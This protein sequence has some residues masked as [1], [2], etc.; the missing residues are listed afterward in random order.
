MCGDRLLQTPTL[1][2]PTHQHHQCGCQASAFPQGICHLFSLMLC[3][4][5]YWVGSQTRHW[6]P[7]LFWFYMTT[8]KKSCKLSVLIHHCINMNHSS[9][10]PHLIHSPIFR[11]DYTFKKKKKKGSPR[12]RI[13]NVSKAQEK[14]TGMSGI[15][16][17]YHTAVCSFFMTEYSFMV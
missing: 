1:A 13:F 15:F 4:L 7:V 5:L 16:V 3:L 14:T 10:G 11:Q 2:L 8:G 17:K 9:H 12:S 6:F